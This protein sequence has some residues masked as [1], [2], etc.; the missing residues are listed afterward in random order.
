MEETFCRHVLAN[1]LREETF[2]GVI[3][4]NA[5]A[6]LN[7]RANLRELVLGEFCRHDLLAHGGQASAPGV[8]LLHFT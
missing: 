2:A 7:E 3:E 5:G 6:L 1:P 8:A 4:K